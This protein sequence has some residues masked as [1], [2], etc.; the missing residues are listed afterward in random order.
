MIK[1][2][3]IAA[4]VIIALFVLLLGAGNLKNGELLGSDGY[5][6]E[7]TYGVG[8][9]NAT[10]QYAVGKNCQKI[11]NVEITTYYPGQDL[12]GENMEGGI[13]DMSGLRQVHTVYG[14]AK[15]QYASSK[16]GNY[17]SLAGDQSANSPLRMSNRSD[18]NTAVDVYI[19]DIEKKFSSLGNYTG[20]QFKVTDTGGAFKGA[21]HY[22][23]D[24]PVIN[25]LQRP[26]A[27]SPYNKRSGGEFK[28]YHTI[29]I[30]SGCPIGL[31]STAPTGSAINGRVP[32]FKQGDSRWGSLRL[33]SGKTMA[34]V[35]CA[36]TSIT[37]VVAANGI[38]MNPGQMLKLANTTHLSNTM[39]NGLY[40]YMAKKAGLKYLQLNPSN[41]SQWDQTMDHLKK[42]ALVIAHGGGKGAVAPF[43]AG[44]HFVVLTSY[45][46]DGTITVN[47][48]YRAIGP[49]NYTE[50][51]IQRGTQAFPGGTPYISIFYK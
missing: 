50:S 22:H 43:T 26:G 10:G 49:T 36:I 39:G 30:G 32:D 33:A 20:I 31:A 51:I 5:N 12:P 16:E 13:N 48:P 40:P 28:E 4:I 15:G 8:N 11:D 25:E 29:Y 21:G 1:K 24:L 42:G 44:G 9:N 7:G 3:S 17:V 47:D 41:S 34:N 27:P 19:P 2:V 23:I 38:N 37:D 6:K 45:N 14:Y 35:G 46:S 18:I